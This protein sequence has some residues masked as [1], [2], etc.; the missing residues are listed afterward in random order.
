MK[1]LIK[2]L[3]LC[4]LAA[5][6]AACDQNKG[7]GNNGGDAPSSGFYEFALNYE[8]A[9][10]EAKDN[11]VS[12]LVSDIA[13]QNIVFNLVPGSAVAS[14]RLTVYPKSMLYNYLLN[15]GR[16][17]GTQEECERSLY[18][19]LSNAPIFSKNDAEYAAKEFDWM[20]SEYSDGPIVPDCEYFIV[21]A[22]Y[23]DAN[24]QNP[25]SLS[26]AHVTTPISPV[27]GDPQL[28]IETEVGYNAFI[29]RYHPN[30]DCKYFYHWV[31]STKE[32]NEYIDLFGEK[33]MRD[34]CRSSAYA[35]NDASVETDLAIKVSFSANELTDR[36]LTA[37]AIALDQNRTPAEF[38]IRNDFEL[39]DIP[40]GNFTPKAKIY[41][42]ERVGATVANLTVEMEKNC[43]SCFYR[44]YTKEEAEQIKA[45]DKEVQDQVALSIAREGWGV[46][47]TN[48]SFNT[49]TETLTGDA[50]KTTDEEQLEL[51][52]DTEYVVA[53]VAKNYFQ[54]LSELCFSETFKTKELVRDTPEA[55]IA[56]DLNLYFTDVSR[57]GF[58]Y[59]FKY[60][61]ST[62]A[63]YRFQLVWPYDADAD[64][65][66]PHYIEDKDNREKW[67]TFFYDTFVPSPAGFEASIVNIWGPE[68]SGFDGYSMYGY[69]SGVTYVFAYCAEDI[70]GVVGPVKFA[71]VTTTK[72]NPGPNPTIVIE[73]LEYDE[74]T[75]AVSGR[76]VANEDTKMIKYIG[77]N[78]GDA[79]FSSCAL[80]DLVNNPNRR[81][82]NDYINLWKGQI[83]ELG[84]D[85]QAESIPFSVNCEKNSN[86]PVLVAAIA[87]GEEKDE[88]GAAVD[89][90]SPIACK[91]YYKGEFK[92][93]SDFRTPPTE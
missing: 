51:K 12:I 50:F 52:P 57:W 53:Y 6:F 2:L 41:A 90:Y 7:T 11:G 31:T 29:V 30:E 87:I 5:T 14:Y 27:S 19:L 3:I 36:K 24:G 81:S 78:S 72:A 43:M 39:I 26:I 16:V 86:T 60:D 40:E 28:A 46:S 47:N 61:Y 92:D 84:L 70:N 93:L 65:I 74:N 77:V 45:S 34:F 15:E 69:D 32:I 83:I 25:A 35:P 79:L 58:T 48:F 23:Y 91:I 49:E 20:N 66:P 73:D 9:G 56:G 18:S 62:T 4:G 68:K 42:G 21:A 88:N 44:L 55:C 64:L 67:M 38:I 22:G 80:N 71:Q 75:G 37:V 82:Y 13:E 76:Y 85:S 10:F 17:D 54:Q 33:M 59:N 89:V 1:R 63:C 8:E